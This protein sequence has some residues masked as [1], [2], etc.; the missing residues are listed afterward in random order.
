[1]GFSLLSV[2]CGLGLLATPFFICELLALQLTASNVQPL[3]RAPAFMRAGGLILAGM[4]MIGAVLVISLLAGTSVSSPTALAPSAVAAALL[5]SAASWLLLT[6]LLYAPIVLLEHSVS[7][8]LALAHSAHTVLRTGLFANLR[9]ALAVFCVQYAPFALAAW[10]VSVDDARAALWVL[11]F[12]PLVCIS[13]PLGQGMLVSAYVQTSERR[14]PFAALP[15]PLRHWVRIWAVLIVLPILSLLLLELGLSR[16]AR[17]ARA[18]PEDLPNGEVVHVLV[19]SARAQSLEL[20]ATALRLQVS[21]GQVSVTASDGGGVGELPL[22]AAEP[23]DRVRVVRVRDSFVI[24]LSQGGS[25]Y[26]TRIDRAGVRLDDDLAARLRDRGRPWQWLFL[27]CTLLFTVLSSAPVLANLARA[28]SQPVAANALFG[29]A[30]RR[31]RLLAL[32]LLPWGAGSLTMALY[33]LFT[34]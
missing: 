13:V 17:I 11:C 29:K 8:E 7:P 22:M 14:A 21:T 3:E 31:A 25:T 10:L 9:L 28:G 1:V 24:E 20:P 6:P 32:L 12:A 4:A 5:G 27:L 18:A 34:A 15:D 19:P 16:P 23:I 33:L 2:C 30:L 26:L